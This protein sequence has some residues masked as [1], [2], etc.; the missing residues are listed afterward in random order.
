MEGCGV[1]VVEDNF[2]QLFVDLFLF[3][4]NHITLAFDGGVFELGVLEDV[5]KNVDGLGDVGVE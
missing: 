4:K 3:A 5:G 1:E 2:F